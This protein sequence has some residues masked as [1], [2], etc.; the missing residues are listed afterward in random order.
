MIRNILLIAVGG[1]TGSVLRYFIGKYF[2]ESWGGSFPWGTMIVN[3]IGCLIIGFIYAL[4]EKMGGM[5]NEIKLF[6]TV[7]LCGGF[8]TFSTFCNENLML[9]RQ[10]HILLAA[11][12]AG[13]S[14]FLGILAVYAGM[15]IVG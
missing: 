14:L 15:K 12:Y 4:D 11:L 7:G 2:Q 9:L 3:L 6:I 13:V 8:T 10:A 1:A 5:N